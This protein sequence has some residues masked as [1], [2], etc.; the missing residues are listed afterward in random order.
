MKSVIMFFVLFTVS[1]NSWAKVDIQTW[2]TDKGVKVFYVYAPQ[3]PMVDINMTFDAGSARDKALWGLSN[4]TSDLIGSATPTLSEAEIAQGFNQYGSQYGSNS[5]K[6]RASI[7]LRSL[8]R[9]EILTPSLSLFAETLSQPVF[10]ADILE[11]ERKR[12]MAGLKQKQVKPSVIASETMWS[13]LYGDHPYAHPT[14]GTL[15]TVPKITLQN[16][17]EFY[18]QYYVAAN[19]QVVIVGNVD[20]QQAKKIAEEVTQGLSKGQK[21]QKL[22]APKSMNKA[23]KEVIQFD[24]TQTHYSLS[25][26]GV[27]R[28][29]K[30]YVALFVGNHLLGGSGFSSMLMKEV[31]EKRGLV[32]SVYS[33]FAPMKVAGPFTIGLSTK[34]ASANEADKVVRE[35]LK[36][37]ITDFSDDAFES[38]K[39]NLIGGFPLRMDS[40]GKI[41]N[42][43]S[44]IGYYGLP[45]DYL[46][47]FPKQIASLTKQDVLKAWQNR[48]EPEKMLNVM[49]GK[50][51]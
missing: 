15:E 40:N 13:N 4:L 33:Y 19:A 20:L 10:K 48:I 14:S 34:N 17:K 36:K 43:V 28:G 5:G 44:M 49:V 25:Q 3:L 30:D 18:Q 21:P 9:P 46:E 24:A 29:D 23:F 35:T 32:Y 16:L 7:F 47:S 11:R 31:R 27:A 42:Y 50:P 12:L 38:I 26:L 8:T 2:Q 41:L 39:A 45:L 22:V 51:E 6:D 37:F 1:F